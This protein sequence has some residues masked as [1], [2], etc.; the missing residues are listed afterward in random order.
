V[1]SRRQGRELALQVL[2]QCEFNP[3]SVAEAVKHFMAW[4]EA[5]PD[6]QAFAMALA[7]GVVAHRED[8]DAR[9]A[10]VAEHWS[11]D[12][13]AAVDR[14]ILRIGVYELMFSPDVPAKVVINEAIE[15]S[16]KFSSVSSSRFVNGVLDAISKKARAVKGDDEKG[17]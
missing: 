15:L 14:N 4:A 17:E 3:Q 6:S 13:M 10:E 2:Y 7:E 8:L 11:V 5:E 9:L 1:K 12:R 16:K